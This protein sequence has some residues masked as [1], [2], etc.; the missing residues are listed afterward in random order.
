MGRMA[1]VLD[2]DNTVY[3][4]KDAY[5]ESLDE[6]ITFLANSTKI[7]KKDLKVSFKRTFCKYGTVEVP[8]AVH[9]LDI[10][11]RIPEK[12]SG[13]IQARADAVFQEAFRDNLRLY[14][15]VPETLDW[16][17]SR[18]ILI[19]AISDATAFWIDFRLQ[20]LGL[21]PY[22][23]KIFARK[24]GSD[25]DRINGRIIPLP[26]EQVK[27]DI[28]ALEQIRTECGL[29]PQDIYVVG[30]SKAKDIRTAQ[31]AG[32]NS[33]WARYGTEC[34]PKNSRLL[35]AV[36]PWTRSQRSAG[37][38]II[39]GHTIDDFAQIKEILEEAGC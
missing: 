24:D 6:E 21:I 15:H 27:P 7:T 28:F 20:V 11:D 10:W 32:M 33:V 31:Q 14:P 3:G 12:E 36:T 9:E 19:F 34:L 25:P 37:G 39:P 1:L 13:N 17:K 29:E 16:A 4:W 22:F 18:G 2:L 5:A 38:N 26:D 30:D 35:S 23:E 8:G